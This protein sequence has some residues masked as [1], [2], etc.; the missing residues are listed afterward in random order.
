M[1]G[2]CCCHAAVM[3]L[4]EWMLAW[5]LNQAV[6]QQRA[7]GGCLCGGAWTGE[8]DTPKS[9]TGERQKQT[10]IAIASA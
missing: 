3:L 4:L 7:P 8:L 9:H 1:Q 5:P 6:L 2:R 10:H